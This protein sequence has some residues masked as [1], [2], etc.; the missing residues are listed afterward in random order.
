MEIK[1][2]NNT[3]NGIFKAYID[4]DFAGEMTY[5][6]A[7][8]TKFIIDSTHVAEGYNGRGVGKELLTALINYAQANNYKILPLCPFA[9]AQFD[10]HPEYNQLLF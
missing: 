8:N 1:H 4:D 2:E 3:K 7:G 6:W 9:K 10:K 5:T